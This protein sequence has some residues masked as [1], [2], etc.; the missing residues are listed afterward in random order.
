MRVAIIGKGNVGSALGAGLQKAGHEVRFGHRSSEEPV[1]AAVKWGEIVLF[2]V[3]FGAVKD[4]AKSVGNAA[5]GKTVID[6]TNALSP[7]ME[8]AIPCSTSA[9]EALQKMLPKSHVIK[10]FN[11]VFAQNQSSGRV[12]TEQ[13]TAFVAGD[14]AASK[15]TVM[16]LAQDIGFAPVDVGGLKNARY[17]E[18][19]AIMLIGLGYGMNLGT[20]IGYR[21]A[22]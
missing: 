14:D 18:A 3:P 4:A 21:L 22:R 8:L 9:A 5:D 17:L 19:M 15:K 13:L 16:R 12:G 11:T 2:A 20:R 10:A 7:T 1:D 6:V